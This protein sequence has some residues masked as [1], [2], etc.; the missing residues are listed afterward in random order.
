MRHRSFVAI[1][2]AALLTA[3]ASAV[4]GTSPLDEGMALFGE[5]RFAEAIP[6]LE[7]AAQA[8][9]SDVLALSNLGIALI[10]VGR[11]SDAE[12]VLGLVTDARP[13]D[14]LAHAYQAIAYNLM[15]RLRLAAQAA[16]RA[17]ELDA[18]VAAAHYSLGLAWGRLG[19]G[20]GAVEEQDWLAR[21]DLPLASQLTA[22]LA[23]L[24]PSD[25]QVDVAG[26][27]G[28]DV[29]DRPLMA[30]LIDETPEIVPVVLE[31]E[32]PGDSITLLGV[33]ADRAYPWDEDEWSGEWPD[34]VGILESW[35]D[36]FYGPPVPDE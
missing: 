11:T 13:D 28:E 32:E 12:E 23:R 5:G 26:A 27:S 33:T 1:I 34:L 14:A 8:D 9:P 36:E 17:L 6:L 4:L 16:Q 21:N 15:E 3:P 10:Q 2:L 22:E 29:T 18:E 20:P 24:D 31:P 25:G 7:Q 35:F 30:S 19:N